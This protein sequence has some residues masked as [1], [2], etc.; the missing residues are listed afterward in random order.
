MVR[1]IKEAMADHD[2]N[3]LAFLNRCEQH[4]L[5]LNHDKLRLRQSEV[6]FIGHIATD[7]GVK[8]DPAKV[9][10][11]A[12]MPP[13]TDKLGVQ[14]LLGLSQYLSKFLPQL[15]D[16]TKPLRDLTQN[17]VQFIWM[18]AQQAAFGELKNAL[19]QLQYCGTI[20]WTRRSHLSAM[21]LRAVWVPH[22]Y[23]TANQ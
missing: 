5:H 3:L 4:D 8:V 19:P 15:S 14:S 11:I 12:D 18:D 9:Q 22:Y 1:A 20:T 2:K 16:I 7:K 6:P 23:R 17:D 10:A 13:P 21:R